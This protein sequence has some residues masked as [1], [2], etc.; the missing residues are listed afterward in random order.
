MPRWMSSA[1]GIFEL[2]RED[3]NVDTFRRANEAEHRIA[4]KTIPPRVVGAVPDKNLGNAFMTRI[5]DN[6]GYRIVAFQH[7]GGGPGLFRC[8]QI[9]SNPGPSPLLPGGR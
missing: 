6:R 8:I 7:F 2:V 3:A 1:E 4:E 9:S 5:L